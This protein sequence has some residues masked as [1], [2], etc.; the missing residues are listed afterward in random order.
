MSSRFLSDCSFGFRDLCPR[1]RNTLWIKS[2]FLSC[3][4]YSIFSAYFSPKSRL[5]ASGRFSRSI[6]MTPSKMIAVF[7]VSKCSDCGESWLSSWYRSQYPDRNLGCHT[8]S[9]NFK[10]RN[11]ILQLLLLINGKSHKS[12]CHLKNH[13]VLRT[14][15]PNC[16]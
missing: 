14:P 1:E 12:I 7:E 8:H 11:R 6:T 4:G 9:P 13:N 15:N 10:N 16:C 2:M 5:M 3:G